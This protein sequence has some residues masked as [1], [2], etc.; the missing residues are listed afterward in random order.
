MEF[1][2]LRRGSTFG[3]HVEN[4][5][6]LVTQ[7]EVVRVYAIP[8]IASVQNVLIARNGVAVNNP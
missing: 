2:F 3:V 7:E 5:R 1:T 4:I 6:M 8:D